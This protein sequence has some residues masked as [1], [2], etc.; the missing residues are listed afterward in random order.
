MRLI[1][2]R[3]DEDDCING[4]HAVV[5]SFGLTRHQLA[6]IIVPVP[7]RFGA[8][9]MSRSTASDSV[10]EKARRV[11]EERLK[12]RLEAE[13]FGAIITVEPESGNTSSAGI[14]KR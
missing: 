10:A 2:D 13:H 8:R 7:S 5:Q 9:I 3:V 1:V 12:S 6:A 14:C 4:V 11:Y